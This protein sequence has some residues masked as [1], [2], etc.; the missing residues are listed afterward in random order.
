MLSQAD[1][2]TR[3]GK[4][5]PGRLGPFRRTAAECP[6]VVVGLFPAVTIEEFEPFRAAEQ[7]RAVANSTEA[8]F[9]SPVSGLPST[10]KLGRLVLPWPMPTEPEGYL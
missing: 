4:V 5:H 9:G 3:C 10:A 7:E 2:C 1:V 8:Q 6:D